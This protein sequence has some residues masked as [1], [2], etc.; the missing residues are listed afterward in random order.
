M[1]KEFV[2]RFGEASTDQAWKVQ[3]LMN[4]ILI[5]ATTDGEE[6]RAAFNAKR[7]PEFTE[8]FAVAAPRGRNLQESGLSGSTTS[9]GVANSRPERTGKAGSLSTITT[10]A[11]WQSRDD[12]RKPGF[13]VLSL[14]EMRR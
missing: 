2:V 5:Q 1:M 8:P 13:R 11:A 10:F 14:V 4:S 3:T 12:E 7:K 9:I 6:G